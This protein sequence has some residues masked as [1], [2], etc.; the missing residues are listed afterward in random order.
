MVSV[1]DVADFFIQSAVVTRQEL[2]TNLR[3]QKMVYYA[4][5]WYVQR[6]GRP[7]FQETIEAWQYGPVIPLLY[8]K[9][10]CY[11]DS[12]IVSTSTG[13]SMDIFTPETLETLL[14]VM[15]EYG[16]Y[17]TSALVNMTHRESEPWYKLDINGTIT[18]EMLKRDFDKLPPLKRIGEDLPTVEAI[19]AAWGTY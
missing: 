6:T 3:V 11:G 13:Y 4:Q 9:Y 17:T 14:D 19:P 12:P 1:Y 15:R 7:L 10:V 8:K 2:M 16:R 18:P 5:A